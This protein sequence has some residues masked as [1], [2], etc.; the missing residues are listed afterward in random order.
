MSTIYHLPHYTKSQFNCKHFS[1]CRQFLICFHLTL[2]GSSWIPNFS[3]PSSQSQKQF[4]DYL[5]VSKFKAIL[6]N[7]LNSR[8]AWEPC[9][10]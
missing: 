4:K 2:I 10:H 7:S 3:M 9:H 8:P 5:S 6:R 1:S